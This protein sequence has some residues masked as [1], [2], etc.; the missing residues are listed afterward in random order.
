M[1][2]QAVGT[3]A[4]ATSR[5]IKKTIGGS[6]TPI[7]RFLISG[8]SGTSVRG[9]AVTAHSQEIGRE[10]QD[11]VE[12]NPYPRHEVPVEGIVARSRKVPFLDRVTE[13]QPGERDGLCGL[14]QQQS[15]VCGDGGPGR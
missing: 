13:Q 3:S 2:E 9:S 8:A 14:Q 15:T 5:S 7:Q 1:V 6:S 11:H 12:R 10:V 4:Y